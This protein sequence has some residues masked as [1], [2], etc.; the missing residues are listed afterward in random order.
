M[1]PPSG[2]YIPFIIFISV[3]FPAPFSPTRTWTSPGCKSKE[4][5]FKARTAPKDFVILESWSRGAAMHELCRFS[6]GLFAPRIGSGRLGEGNLA[7][8]RVQAAF[9]LRNV[10][11]ENKRNCRAVAPIWQ[12]RVPPRPSICKGNSGTRWNASLPDCDL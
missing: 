12:G 10:R 4:T 11:D 2:W 3:D 8:A 5:P 7:L 9:M 1:L 6:T